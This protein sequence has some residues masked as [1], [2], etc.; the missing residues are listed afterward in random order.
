[1]SQREL[2]DLRMKH[3]QH[4]VDIDHAR[5]EKEMAVLESIITK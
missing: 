1:M 5:M 3:E 4:L 2:I